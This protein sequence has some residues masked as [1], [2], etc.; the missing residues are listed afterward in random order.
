M[1]EEEHAKLKALMS[2]LQVNPVKG[3]SAALDMHL[4]YER[5]QLSEIIRKLP[6]W[7]RMWFKATGRILY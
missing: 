6:W 1:S 2:D 4:G 5:Q 7:K 3:W